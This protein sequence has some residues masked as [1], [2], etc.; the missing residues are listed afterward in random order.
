MILNSIHLI[1]PN[2]P[3]QPLSFKYSTNTT[4]LIVDSPYYYR[5]CLVAQLVKNLPT[6][7][8]TPARFLGWEELLEKG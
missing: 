3:N 2:K 8:E 1:K 5:A 7:Q 6:M 4:E